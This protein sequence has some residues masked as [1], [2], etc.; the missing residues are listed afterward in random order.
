MAAATLLNAVT[1]NTVGAGVAI[2][3]DFEASALGDAG[4][5]MGELQRSI[6]DVDANYKPVGTEGQFNGAGHCAVRNVG[7]NYYRGVLRGCSRTANF[8]LKTNQ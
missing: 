7:T 4:G 8:T 2:S 1:T 3:G 6:D 5:G